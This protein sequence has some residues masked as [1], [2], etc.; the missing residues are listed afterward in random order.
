[1]IT[2]EQ[3]LEIIHLKK[4]IIQNDVPQAS[5]N[6][7]QTYPMN[8]RF[9]LISQED[10]GM[11]FLWEITQSAKD[12]LRI[13]LHFQDDDSKIGL[14]RVDYNGGHHNPEIGNSN[15]PEIFKPYIGKYF[16]NESHVHYH[17]EGYKTLAWALPIGETNVQVK[18]IDNKNRNQQVIDAILGFA[19]LINVETKITIN[20]MLI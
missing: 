6:I 18:E 17:V 3:T 19:E 5:I 9:E 14:F 12:S 8:V 1:M 2:Y 16:D 15:L 13:S 10:D 7:D 20:P 11:A 4:K